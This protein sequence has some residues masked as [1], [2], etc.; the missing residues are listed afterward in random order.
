M[1]ART[2]LIASLATLLALLAGN[3]WAGAGA[4][5]PSCRHRPSTAAPVDANSLKIDGAGAL[6]LEVQRRGTAIEVYA[7][8]MEVPCSGEPPTIANVTS[9][10]AFGYGVAFTVDQSGGPF[11]LSKPGG[12]EE[13]EF[14]LSGGTALRINGHSG[15]DSILLGSFGNRMVANLNR[16]EDGGP[17]GWDVQAFLGPASDGRSDQV[18]VNGGGGADRIVARGEGEAGP[19]RADV[20]YIR[21][22]SGSDRLLGSPGRDLLFGD[23]Q[24]DILV[25]GSGLDR[26]VP[27]LGNDEARGGRGPDRIDVV[28]PGRKV[29]VPDAGRD[30]AIGGPGG[31]FVLSRDRAR[32]VIF[33]GSG[34]DTARADGSDRR[35]GCERG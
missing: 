31:D 33:C 4:T 11:A 7:D 8:G 23:G 20:L 27:G 9:V 1:A 29:E 30:L 26:L 24:N 19:L 14:S 21:A 2:S 32:D 10:R 22:G 16:I 18:V 12:S 25:G 35:V 15:A 6:I 13:I 3:S 5:E 28:S 17:Q 34:R